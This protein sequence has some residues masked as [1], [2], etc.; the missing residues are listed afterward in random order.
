MLEKFASSDGMCVRVWFFSGDIKVLAVVERI[1]LYRLFGSICNHFR[2]SWG[3]GDQKVAGRVLSREFERT[4][5]QVKPA[6]LL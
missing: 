5:R 2:W 4:E 3:R 1:L 6:Y